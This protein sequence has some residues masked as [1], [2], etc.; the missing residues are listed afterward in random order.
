MVDFDNVAWPTC[1][2]NHLVFSVFQIKL[3]GLDAPIWPGKGI[4]VT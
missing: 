2:C 1:G 4:V 3:S